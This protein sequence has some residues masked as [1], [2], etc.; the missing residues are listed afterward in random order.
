MPIVTI[1]SR[2]SDGVE[3]EFRIDFGG[4]TADVRLTGLTLPAHPEGTPWP[5]F[6]RP[7]LAELIGVVLDPKAIWRDHSA[8]GQSNAR[9]EEVATQI[10]AEMASMNVGP[11]TKVAVRPLSLR[12]AT[13]GVTVSEFLDAIGRLVDQGLA[14]VTQGPPMGMIALTDEGYKRSR[15]P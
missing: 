4:R 9:T 15:N 14:N 5:E 2:A 1:T 12:S 10:L 6:Y 8:P 13:H 11:W 3:A 7:I